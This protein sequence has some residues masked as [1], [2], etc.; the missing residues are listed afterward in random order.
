MTDDPDRVDC[1]RFPKDSADQV[2]LVPAGMGDR[3]VAT[4]HEETRR[5]RRVAYIAVAVVSLLTA[6]AAVLTLGVTPVSVGGTV[7]VAG[8]MLLALRRG[9]RPLA[10][11]LVA[12]DLP[13][14]EARD[15]YDVTVTTTDPTSGTAT[16]DVGR[17]AAD[18]SA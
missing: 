2:R 6:G 8:V 15:R 11:D 16:T 13:A 14:T 12:A 1:L 18:D 3:I 5:R 4:H 10:P 9:D 7:L 17:G